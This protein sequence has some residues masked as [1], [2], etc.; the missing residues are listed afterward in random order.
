MLSVLNPLSLLSQNMLVITIVVYF[1]Y[2][3]GSMYLQYG[4]D[5]NRPR[6][7]S[8]TRVDSYCTS[9]CAVKRRAPC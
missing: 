9:D 3:Q 1:S 4:N 2:T 6:F 5:I 8:V 7:M